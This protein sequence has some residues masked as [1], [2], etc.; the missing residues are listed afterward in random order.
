MPPTAFRTR[1]SSYLHLSTYLVGAAL[2][3]G[4]FLP[5]TAQAQGFG[6]YEQ[7]TCVMARAGA[8]VASGCDDG[9]SIYFNP[10]HL[11]DTD[12]LTVSLG[13]TM[14]DATGE[15]TYDYAAQPPYRGAEVSLENDPIPVPH[16]YVTYGLTDRIG[17]GLGT[18]VPFGL[19]TNWPTRLSD[20]SVFDGA[21]EGFE[22]RIQ[23]I[24]VQPTL[25]YQVT[26]RLQVGAGPVLGISSVEL[27]QLLDLSQQAVRNPATGEAVPDPTSEDPSEP[28]RFSQLGIPFHTAF[29]RSSLESSNDLGIG[30]NVGLSYR[31][32]DRIS[33]GARFTTPITVTY[34][35]E[36]DFT[37][38]QT[39]LQVPTDLTLNGQT[40]V[41]AGTPIDGLLQGQFSGGQLVSQDVETEITFP[42]QLVT[43]LS[44]QATESLLLLADYQLT[45]WSAF[46]EIPL[47]F[48]NL[49]K[50]VR[51]ENYENTHAVRFGAEVDLSGTFTARLGYLYNTAA[52]PDGVVTPLLP[53]S[54]RNQITIG[55]GWQ[56]SDR[57]EVNVSYQAL[58]QNDRR[59]RVR[60][61]L[62]NEPV[63]T[64]LNQGVYGFGANLFGTTL[65]FHL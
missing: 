6:V 24:Y 27:N 59:G 34:D 65:T 9:S 38:I 42:F 8:A 31:V 26:P 52:A 25:A 50:Q 45:G 58:L 63:T 5:G 28:L 36:A 17:L 14:I 55:F 40:L 32:T 4:A 62:P 35:G 10:S 7:G 21:F 48:E 30:A 39:G 2:A 3:L 18:Y 44:V 57:T 51:E 56:P 29:A 49:P 41:P 43:G 19:E 53:E 1:L 46:D 23:N 16:A 37:Q 22:N 12:G 47:E 64:D 60:G 11:A 61:G 54:D 15:F 13:A 33:F 20:G